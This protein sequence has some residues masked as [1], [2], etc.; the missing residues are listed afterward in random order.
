M[1]I[2]MVICPMEELF[3]ANKQFFFF[4]KLTTKYC[5]L[6]DRLWALLLPRHHAGPVKHIDLNQL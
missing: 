5:N 6:L 1:H 2:R 4:F 3:V